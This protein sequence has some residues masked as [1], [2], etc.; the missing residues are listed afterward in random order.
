[1][2]LKSLVMILL[3]LVRCRIFWFGKIERAKYFSPK[4]SFIELQ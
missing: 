2:I 3:G 4:N 1:M